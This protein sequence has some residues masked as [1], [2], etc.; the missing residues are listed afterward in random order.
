MQDYSKAKL[1]AEFCIA[2]KDIVIFEKISFEICI[3]I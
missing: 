3:K 2:G 1:R